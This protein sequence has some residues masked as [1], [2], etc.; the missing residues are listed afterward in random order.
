MWHLRAQSCGHILPSDNER[1]RSY[2][3]KSWAP[4]TNFASDS[5][6]NLELP[7]DSINS[8]YTPDS[9][10]ASPGSSRTSTNSQLPMVFNTP[11]QLAAEHMRF[12]LAGLD[13]DEEDSDSEAGYLDSSRLPNNL[14]NLERQA[15]T[16]RRPNSPSSSISSKNNVP[17]S[18][19]CSYDPKGFQ[20]ENDGLVSSG[21][22]QSSNFNQDSPLT[23]MPAQEPTLDNSTPR[24]GMAQLSNL[25]FNP[26]SGILKARPHRKLPNKDSGSFC[27]GLASSDS[28]SSYFALE[29]ETT[30]NSALLGGLSLSEEKA[31]SNLQVRS[32]L[33]GPLLAQTTSH[34]FVE[35]LPTDRPKHPSEDRSGRFASK[36]LG[37]AS[38]FDIQVS[39]E[40]GTTKDA[41]PFQSNIQAVIIDEVPILNQMST[42]SGSLRQVC[43]PDTNIYDPNR[44]KRD[45]FELYQTK[46]QSIAVVVSPSPSSTVFSPGDVITVTIRLKNTST[47]QDI[48]APFEFEQQLSKWKKITFQ[49]SGFVTQNGTRQDSTQHEI[50]N[51]SQVLH[52]SEHQANVQKSGW[53]FQVNIPTHVNCNCGPGHLPLPSTCSNSVGHVSYFLSVRGKRKTYMIKSS[54]G[55][56][57]KIFVDLRIRNNLLSNEQRLVTAPV[58]FKSLPNWIGLSGGHKA[59]VTNALLTYQVQFLSNRNLM[60]RYEVDL[61]LS[62]DSELIESNIKLFEEISSNLNVT[63]TSLSQLI[64]SE[65]LINAGDHNQSSKDDCRIKYDTRDVRLNS[66]LIRLD[67]NGVAWRVSGYLHMDF[68][69]ATENLLSRTSSVTSGFAHQ[70]KSY[71]PKQQQASM[72]AEASASQWLLR[73]TIQSVLLTQ[74]INVCGSL[75]DL[76]STCATR[77]I[78]Q[79]MPLTPR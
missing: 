73:A 22:P 34:T 41:K 39:N 37:I 38:N 50:F 16:M 77:S 64:N 12:I 29:S 20:I 7:G 67:S 45:Q 62:P 43:L 42:R 60:I 18:F 68:L 72:P 5:Q 13:C 31:S 25:T 51:L 69:R 6:G 10:M 74:P 79:G 40:E 61:K 49:M 24:G 15:A 59:A 1:A 8:L 70:L 65:A 35:E 57:S 71:Y 21:A 52:F 2:S 58:T 32:P 76:Q 53:H 78:I 17:T 47:H 55:A 9:S 30:D 66:E 63:V 3:N 19:T 36:A 4:G 33:S 48:I 27:F 44:S 54:P 28:E 46:D 14:P 75:S 26:E 23:R 56:E 11:V